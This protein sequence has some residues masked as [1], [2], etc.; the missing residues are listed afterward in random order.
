M[1]YISGN[2]MGVRAKLS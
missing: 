2:L 1:Y